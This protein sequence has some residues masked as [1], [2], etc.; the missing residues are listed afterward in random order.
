MNKTSIEEWARPKPCDPIMMAFGG[1]E[2]F[3]KLLPPWEI[4]PD[5]FKHF[6]G[7][8]NHFMSDWFYCGLKNFNPVYKPGVDGNTAFTHLR[9]IIGSF[10]PKHEHKEAAV[11]WLASLWLE[12][13]TT[14]E[15][16]K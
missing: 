7:R 12:N 15:R 3:Q 2:D 16:A 9:T 10:E 1:G 13:S 6:N 14:W 11:A 4:I 8:W 5:E